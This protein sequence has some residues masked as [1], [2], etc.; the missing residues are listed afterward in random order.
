MCYGIH[1]MTPERWEQVKGMIK[2]KF[3]VESERTED[4]EDQSPGSIEII[5]FTGPS[6]KIRLEYTD[7]PLKMGT[8][9]MGSKRIGSYTAV[10][11]QYSDTE[12]VH[13]FTAYRWEEDSSSW[14]ELRGPAAG[15][16]IS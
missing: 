1:A 3:G 9:G 16:F 12:R 14:I 13:R 6:G 11:H 10:V 2:D 8:R 5:E 7:E 4:L 15:A